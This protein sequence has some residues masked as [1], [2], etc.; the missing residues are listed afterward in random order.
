M[1]RFAAFILASLYFAYVAVAIAGAEHEEG[2]CPNIYLAD[3]NDDA[4]NSLDYHITNCLFSKGVHHIPALGKVKVPCI[5][6]ATITKERCAF[7]S[8]ASFPTLFAGNN[9]LLPPHVPLYIRNCVF[10]I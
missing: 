3:T 9:N 10:R 7:T 5:S 2:Y 8:A 6:I 4:A 1:K